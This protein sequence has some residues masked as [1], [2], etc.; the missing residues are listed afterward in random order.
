MPLKQMKPSAR[1]VSF[2]L[3]VLL[4]DSERARSLTRSAFTS[5]S[6]D[7]NSPI[8]N[9][10]RGRVL[11]FADGESLSAPETEKSFEIK[12]FLNQRVFFLLCLLVSCYLFATCCVFFWVTFRGKYPCPNLA[13]LVFQN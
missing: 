1:M 8:G 4:K 7:E 9:C 10:F 12:V 13:M 11:A 6:G 2:V 5:R 3:E